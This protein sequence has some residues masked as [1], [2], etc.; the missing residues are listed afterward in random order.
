MSL[1]TEYRATEEAINKLKQRLDALSNNPGLLTEMEFE[2]KL[3][4]LMGEYR[5]SLRD[6]IAI[7][8]PQRAP[9][10]TVVPFTR[11][12]RALKVYRHPDSGEV[13]QTKRWQSPRPESVETAIGCGHR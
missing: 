1:I 10:K 11:K 2:D 7:L 5:K 4:A 6:I 3:R 8:D 9:L 13:V 12:A